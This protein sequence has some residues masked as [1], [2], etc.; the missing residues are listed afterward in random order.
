[1]TQETKKGMWGPVPLRVKLLVLAQ[2]PNSLAFGYLVIYLTAYFPETGIGSD[3]VGLIIGAEGLVLVLSGIPFALLSDR[4]G[5][6]WLVIAGNAIFAPTILIFALTRNIELVFVAAMLGGLGEA[7][8][9]S[10]WNALLAD[11]TDLTNRDSTFS[12]SFIVGGAGFGLGSALP[13]AFPPLESALNASAMAV[14]SSAFLFLGVGSFVTPALY[15]FLLRGYKERTPEK[16]EGGMKLGGLGQTL[17]FSV[18]N[19]FIGLGA[20]LIIPLM[21]T[22][23]LYKFAVRDTYSGPYLALAGLT[24]AFS[25]IASPWVS[26]KLGLFRAVI[27]TAGSSTLFMLA[28]AFVTNVYVAAGVYLVRAGLMNMNAPLMDSFLMGITEPKRRGLA[29]TLNA[30]IWRL[31]NNVSTVLGGVILA[32][33]AYGVPSIGL[34][35]LDVPWVLAAALYVLGL[36]LLYANFRNVKPTG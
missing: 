25:A 19:S 2:F 10:S 20:G 17:K 7:M 27:T 15:L 33:P 5:R 4:K 11:Q 30:I 3:V 22:W 31:P 9:L 6:K 18:F 36:G 24:I 28:L 29:S 12:L 14:H 16:K 8:G 23:L 21:A 26:K 34:T 1:M 32:S 13:L 35:N